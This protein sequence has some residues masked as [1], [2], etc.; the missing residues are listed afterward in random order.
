MPLGR[1]RAGGKD[2]LL[3]NTGKM[4]TPGHGTAAPQQPLA[5]SCASVGVLKALNSGEYPESGNA[6]G[7]RDLSG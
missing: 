5:R 6:L 2:A 4:C 7:G 3:G 1:G